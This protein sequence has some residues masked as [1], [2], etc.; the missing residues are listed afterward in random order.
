[1]LS[2]GKEKG[3]TMQ[4]ILKM[5]FHERQ[6]AMSSAR[7]NRELT[8]MNQEELKKKE[9]AKNSKDMGARG[10]DAFRQLLERRFGSVVKAWRKAL[11][12]DGN[13]ILSFGEFATACRT[14]GYLGNVKKLWADLD[15]DGGGSI[16]LK[17]LDPKAEEA[18][19]SFK[20][21]LLAKYGNLTVAWYYGLD[22]NRNMR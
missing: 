2:E 3:P 12:S 16:S 18:I 17:E 6:N 11:D 8:L 9:E 10:L 7:W 5:S 1:M 13:G 4:E 19:L 21:L 22:I 14:V 15:T 20:E